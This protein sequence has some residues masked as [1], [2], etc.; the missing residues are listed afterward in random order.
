MQNISYFDF[1]WLFMFGNL[2]GVLVEGVWCKIRYGKWETHS[3]T[4]LGAFNLVYGI[5]LP[6]FYLGSLLISQY[7]WFFIFV[8]MALLG[9]LVEYLCGLLLRIGLKM[10]AW[11]YRKHFWNIQGI[12]S[13]KMFFIW[14]ILGVIFSQSL[15]DP[16]QNMLSYMTGWWWNLAGIILTVYMIGNLLLT[17]VCVIRWSNRHQG[18]AAANRL[19]QWIDQH[20]P[21]AK[22][23]KKFFYWHFLD[24]DE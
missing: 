5:G 11:D 20:Y 22:I 12:I 16:I 17:L 19:T 8:I 21:D 3:V 13:L 6:V 10:R 18:K 4:I 14:G 1:F 9:S 23:E 7:H 15:L 2:A 24:E